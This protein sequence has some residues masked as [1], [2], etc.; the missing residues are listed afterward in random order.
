MIR[1][2]GV[3]VSVSG[4]ALAGWLAWSGLRS[5]DA[6]PA[7]AAKTPAEALQQQLLRQNLDHPGDPVG[8]R[9]YAEDVVKRRVDYVEGHLVLPSGPGLGMELDPELMQKLESPL[10]WGEE[11][12]PSIQDRTAPSAKSAP[13][14]RARR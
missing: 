11:S 9:L 3:L 6:R 10:Q 2:S 5:L 12:L 8:P 1:T 7:E 14:R 4:L 13:R